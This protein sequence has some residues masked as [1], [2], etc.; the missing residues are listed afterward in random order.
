MGADLPLADQ[1]LYGRRK[2]ICQAETSRNPARA[3]A[4]PVSQLL[5]AEPEAPLQL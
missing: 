5:Q 1:R 2:I 3:T 4:E